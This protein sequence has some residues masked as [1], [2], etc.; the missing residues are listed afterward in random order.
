MHL[1]TDLKALRLDQ[2]EWGLIEALVMGGKGER[3]V[4]K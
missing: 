2:A 3:R 1:F 4:G